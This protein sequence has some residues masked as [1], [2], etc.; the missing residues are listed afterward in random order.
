MDDQRIHE[1]SVWRILYP[2]VLF[3]V[4]ILSKC[5]YGFIMDIDPHE[6]EV[7]FYDWISAW[8]FGFWAAKLTSKECK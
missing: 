8:W 1:R 6:W 5:A 2:I 4:T 3:F 7:T